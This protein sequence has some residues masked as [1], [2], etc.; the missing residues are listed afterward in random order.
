MAKHQT[1]RSVSIRG[2]TYDHVRDYCT[3]AAV[4]MSDFVEERIAAFFADPLRAAPPADPVPRKPAP[5]KPPIV[6]RVTP[7]ALPQKLTP[8]ERSRP[9]LS[10]HA[11]PPKKGRDGTTARKPSPPPAPRVLPDPWARR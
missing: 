1:R 10:P 4:S 3:E 11:P 8:L 2:A 9:P 6:L 5:A 7:P